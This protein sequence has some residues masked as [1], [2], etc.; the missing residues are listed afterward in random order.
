M[1]MSI[2]RLITVFAA[3]APALGPAANVRAVT[4]A[5]ARTA[6]SVSGFDISGAT[7]DVSWP[8]VTAAGARFVFITATESTSVQYPDF[9]G[10]SAG[11]YDAGL[12]RGA[13]HLAIPSASRG[14]TQAD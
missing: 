1:T 6:S 14:A 9:A 12:I 5:S 10:L 11:A 13:V 8:R 4:P 3:A 2:R 7:T